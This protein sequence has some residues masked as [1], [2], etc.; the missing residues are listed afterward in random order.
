MY[1]GGLKHIDTANGPGIRVSL[2]V[3]GCT[4]KCEDCFNPE[5]WDFKHGKEFNYETAYEIINALKPDHINGLTILGGEP[6]ELCNQEGILP[7]IRL[8]KR[9][10]PTKSIWVYT[11]FKLDEDLIKGGKRYCEYTN[12]ILSNIDVLVDGK[13]DKTLKD[14]K[15]KFRGSSN[16][17]IIDMK[18]TIENKKIILLDL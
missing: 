15:L 10:T 1:Y 6:F 4:N 17:R 3:S 5:T 8:V 12:E 7:L 14:L 9:L 2:F 13:F 16:Q 11:G 18:K